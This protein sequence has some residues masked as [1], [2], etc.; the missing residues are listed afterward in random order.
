M[1]YM[2]S[3]NNIIF[4]LCLKFNRVTQRLIF[5]YTS[6]SFRLILI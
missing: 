6:F 2:Y 3:Q 4:N 5:Q 1:Y